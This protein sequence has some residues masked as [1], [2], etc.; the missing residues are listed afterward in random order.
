[1]GSMRV[2]FRRR[3]LCTWHMKISRALLRTVDNVWG[4]LS[5]GDLGSLDGLNDLMDLGLSP[6]LD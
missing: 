3:F 4:G 5:A 6:G 1:V 2:S